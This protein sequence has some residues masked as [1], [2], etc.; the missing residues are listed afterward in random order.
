ML[1]FSLYKAQND[2][3]NTKEIWYER[4]VKFE[5]VSPETIYEYGISLQNVGEYYK[6]KLAFEEFLRHEPNDELEL[7][8][9]ES[10]NNILTIWSDLGS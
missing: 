3:Y 9:L 4:A 1:G 6:A 10:C 7:L 2:I 8:K 5:D